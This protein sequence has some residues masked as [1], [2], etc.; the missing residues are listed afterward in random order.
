MLWS[1]YF[2][3]F[4]ILIILFL[5][6][7]DTKTSEDSL[8]QT[9]QPTAPI[10]DS[11]SVEVTRDQC[12]ALATKA[13]KIACMNQLKA[14]RAT[15]IAALKEELEKVNTKTEVLTEI[16]ES[17]ADKVS[18]SPEPTLLDCLKLQNQMK[19]DACKLEV[20]TK[21]EARLGAI[22]IKAEEK[23]A[24]LAR[25]QA[26]GETLQTT[27]EVLSEVKD[28]LAD[29]GPTPVSANFNDLAIVTREQCKTLLPDRGEFKSCMLAY[30]D[31][32]KAEIN[33]K[34][35]QRARNELSIKSQE[36]ELMKLDTTIKGLQKVILIQEKPTLTLLDCLKIEDQPEKHNCKIKVKSQRE[37]K[38]VELNERLEEIK[39]TNE[40][41]KDEIE[42][43]KNEIEGLKKVIAIQEE[44]CR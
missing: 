21:R 32:Q 1:K 18:D 7:C 9:N 26:E 14:Q 43:L 25:V 35:E 27:I 8:L 19:K 29:E 37:A 38:I 36:D 28:A 16:K 40:N 15:E 39:T 10:G 2:A 12:M 23:K 34:K 42:R 30:S 4:A 22:R 11:I 44:V 31:H 6:G 41:E 13:E 24:E 5:V 17:L 33:E 20:K 3:L